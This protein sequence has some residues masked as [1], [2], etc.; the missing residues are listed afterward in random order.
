MAKKKKKVEKPK[1]YT[2]RQLS[3]F[4][5]ARRRQRITFISGISII[6]AIILI[7][8]GGWFS[9]DYIPLHRTMLKVN[10]VKF[11]VGYYI[12][13]MKVLRKSDSTIDT[14]T[15]A[16]Q[17][18]QIMTEGEIVRQGAEKLGITVSKDEVTTL[19]DNL[20][21]PDSEGF[22]SVYGNQILEQ[23]VKNSYFGSKAPEKDTQVHALIMMLE[24][25]RRAIEVRQ[26]LVNG[27]NFT[28]LASEFG[29][30]YY[31]K[32]V[33]QGD[34]GWHVRDVLKDQLSSAIPLDYAFSAEIGTL[35][36]PLSDNETYKQLGYWLIKLVDRPEEGK[37]H[38]KALVVSDNTT[39]I[40]VKARLE[41]GTLSLA[42]AVEEYNSYSLSDETVGDF[43]VIDVSEN[44]T[45]TGAFNTYVWDPDKPIGQWSDPVLE[46][47][48]WTQGGSWLVQ[49]IEK[50]D[51]REVSEEDRNH[52]IEKAY[53]NWYSELTSKPDLIIE[54]DLLS[55]EMRQ[56]AMERLDKEYPKTQVQTQ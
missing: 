6:A 46:K 8:A 14:A 51:N 13:V 33:N 47:K 41:A 16:Y 40:D 5:K 45:Y 10:G 22:R 19:L 37:V 43:G 27:D 11:N 32:N 54:D 50:E 28:T 42:D 24:S 39:A 34:Y 2:R 25:D 1:E 36:P 4:K 3:H 20:N 9:S 55:D 38:V 23:K 48:L 56:W 21:L 29:Q 31:S 26:R 44:G 53:D 7:I 17:A 18:V 52:L 12:D 35:S 30:D 49:V 15:L